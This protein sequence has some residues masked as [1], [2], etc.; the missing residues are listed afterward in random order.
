MPVREGIAT[1]ARRGAAALCLA[2]SIRVGFLRESAAYGR[3]LNGDT[4]T[5]RSAV[6]EAGD[7]EQARCGW[8]G[9]P[10]RRTRRTLWSRR[11]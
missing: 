2:L 5:C 3:L 11:P 10:G 9:L 1:A 6:L 8:G 4:R 7:G